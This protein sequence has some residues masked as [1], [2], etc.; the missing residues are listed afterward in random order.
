MPFQFD[1]SC[2]HRSRSSFSPLDNLIKYSNFVTVWALVINRLRYGRT[3]GV[4]WDACINFPTKDSKSLLQPACLLS[5]YLINSLYVN[6]FVLGSLISRASV[7]IWKP[8]KIRYVVGNTFF[9]GAIGTLRKSK[10]WNIV[11][12]SRVHSSLVD[13]MPTPIKSSR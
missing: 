2:D 13:E 7:S 10:I 4:T 1:R 6:N 3:V 9:S 12:M 5:R 8:K 11:F